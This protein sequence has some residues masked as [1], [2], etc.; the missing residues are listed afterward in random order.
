MSKPNSDI[1][2]LI[3]NFRTPVIPDKDK[4]KL[5]EIMQDFR[6]EAGVTTD[7]QT[8][9]ITLVQEVQTQI[10]RII[11]EV[12]VNI[13]KHVKAKNARIIYNNQMLIGR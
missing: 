4:E 11:S 13:K 6:E 2:L 1:R 3:D 7:L 10:L 12:L 5:Q 9:T 8:D